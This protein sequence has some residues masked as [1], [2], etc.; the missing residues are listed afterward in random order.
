MVLLCHAC[1]TTMSSHH[2]DDEP[3]RFRASSLSFIIA[4]VLHLV[5]HSFATSPSIIFLCTCAHCWMF[6]QQLWFF[7][8]TFIVNHLHRYN[9]YKCFYNTL[10][11][12]MHC[13][14]RRSCI[15]CSLFVKITCRRSYLCLASLDAWI[16]N[17]RSF[18]NPFPRFLSAQF[19]PNVVCLHVDVSFLPSSLL[20]SLV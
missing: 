1:H 12:C 16:T 11:R 15:A 6:S 4:H 19:C 10:F 14:I 3:F 17:G 20:P 13:L 7:F 5:S 9:C 8:G 18:F 2:H